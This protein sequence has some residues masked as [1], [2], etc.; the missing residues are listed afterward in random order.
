[1]LNPPSF[2]PI[3]P[4]STSEMDCNENEL[5]ETVGR[6]SNQLERALQALREYRLSHHPK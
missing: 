5:L 4:W 3:N 6:L 2:Y 1:M